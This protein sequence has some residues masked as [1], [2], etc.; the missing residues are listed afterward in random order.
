[1]GRHKTEPVIV[2]YV[3]GVLNAGDAD[4]PGNYN[5]ITVARG[6]KRSKG[7]AISGASYNAATNT[8]TLTTAKK[9]VLNPPLRLTVNSGGLLDILGRPLNGNGQPGGDFVATLTPAGATV[10]SAVVLSQE[11]A[12]RDDVVDAVLESEFGRA[13]KDKK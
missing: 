8:V 1:M 3:S 9:L 12:F 5:L 4:N 6:K 11:R 2:L 10:E 7:V 13:F